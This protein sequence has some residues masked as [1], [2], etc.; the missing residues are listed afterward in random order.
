MA[1]QPRFILPGQR[2]HVVQRGNNRQPIFATTRDYEFYLEKLLNA[3]SEHECQIHAYVLMTNHVHLLVS[4]TKVEGLSKMMQMLGRYYVQYFNYNYQR[5]G[6][7]W[8]GR[9]KACL[10]SSEQYLFTCMRYIE[11]NP[12][13]AGMVE[14]P[15]G[16]HWSSYHHNALGKADPLIEPHL[17]YC[18]L[19]KTSEEQQRGYQALFQIPLELKILQEVREATNKC[20]TLG[21]NTFKKAVAQQLARRVEPSAK[22]GDRKSKKYRE[23]ATINPV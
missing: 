6:T 20:W 23:I 9:Y 8:E 2:Q 3:A 19:G 7:L 22:G 15:I 17:E 21:D 11:L 18:K 5:T 4:P 10:I 1:R 13:R 14:E 16:Y 12:V